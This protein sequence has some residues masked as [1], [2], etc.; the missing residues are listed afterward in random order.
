MATPVLINFQVK[1]TGYP[2]MLMIIDSFFCRT[3]SIDHDICWQKTLDYVDFKN[4]AGV[5]STVHGPSARTSRKCLPGLNLNI[6][7]PV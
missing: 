1:D 5:R 7:L 3:T 4:Q 6:F 2:M